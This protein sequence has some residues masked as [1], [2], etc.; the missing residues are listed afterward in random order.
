M[1]EQGGEPWPPGCPVTKTAG[2]LDGPESLASREAEP[3]Q[4]GRGG[5]PLPRGK[6]ARTEVWR[7][8]Q[9]RHQAEIRAE[10]G[11]RRKGPRPRDPAEEVFPGPRQHSLPS[12]K[13]RETK[14]GDRRKA[15]RWNRE[16]AREVRTGAGVSVPSLQTSQP[17]RLAH[18]EAQGARRERRHRHRRRRGCR[19][20]TA[21]R[22]W[23][24]QSTVKAKDRERHGDRR[25]TG[26]GS[27]LQ[28]A[29]TRELG[30]PFLLKHHPK[31]PNPKLYPVKDDLGNSPLPGLIRT[32]RQGQ[33]TG[34]GPGDGPGL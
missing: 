9:T 11:P 10:G 30:L 5:N 12:E 19:S 31:A 22:I 14:E 2:S 21:P 6:E 23:A 32:E 17:P 3:R 15:E 29:E 20:H 13:A 34:I 7:E 28:E 1:R 33:R 8:G 16:A 4:H 24:S 26:A 18:S 25:G 27:A